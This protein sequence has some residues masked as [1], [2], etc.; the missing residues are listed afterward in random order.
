MNDSWEGWNELETVLGKNMYALTKDCA[1]RVD[2]KLYSNM[3][4]LDFKN[5]LERIFI[6]TN[7]DGNLSPDERI[8]F[9]RK[10]MEAAGVVPDIIDRVVAG[11]HHLFAGAAEILDPEKC[12]K[13]EDYQ[14]VLHGNMKEIVKTAEAKT[15]ARLYNDMN[16]TEFGSVME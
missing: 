12:Q 14:A 11:E 4:A 9:L 2:N 15:E 7:K 8:H 1:N 13:W 6:A 3:S 16:P 5:T 10:V